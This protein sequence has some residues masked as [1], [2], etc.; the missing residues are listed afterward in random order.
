MEK[1]LTLSEEDNVATA[2]APLEPGERVTVPVGKKRL[3]VKIRE[4]IPFGHKF[5]IND[6]GDGGLV[7]KYGHDIGAATSDIKTGQH[8][9]VHNVKTLRGVYS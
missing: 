9:H 6:I 1:A 8:V 2:I 5:A 4:P 7:V 3:E